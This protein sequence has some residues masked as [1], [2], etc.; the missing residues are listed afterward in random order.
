VNEQIPKPADGAGFWL[1]GRRDGAGSG[2]LAEWLASGGRA[3][4]AKLL[5]AGVEVA[6]AWELAAWGTTAPS[7]R[8][9][10]A[11]GWGGV[12]PL[13]DWIHWLPE[14]ASSRDARQQRGGDG[15][16]RAMGLEAERRR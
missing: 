3:P 5:S 16:R 15:D 9:V 12:A 8:P 2:Y 6:D 11:G 14:Q 7:S 4:V 13:D 10:A 1:P